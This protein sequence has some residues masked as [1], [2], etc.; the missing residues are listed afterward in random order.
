MFKATEEGS[1]RKVALKKSRVSTR[2]KRP[3]LQ[4]ETRV[5]QLLRGHV[6]IPIVFGYGQ[7]EHFEYL[8]MEFLGPTVT[9]KLTDNAGVAVRTVLRVV[10]QVVRRI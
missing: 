7:H 4:H 2:V 8:S 3:T 9:E 6:A 1:G 5:L 10:D